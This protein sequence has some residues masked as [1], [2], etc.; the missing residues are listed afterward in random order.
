MDVSGGHGSNQDQSKDIFNL[1]LDVL[2]DTDSDMPA[3]M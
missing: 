3:H 2:I 1:I